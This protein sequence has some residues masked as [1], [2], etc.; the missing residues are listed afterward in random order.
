[1]LFSN[2]KSTYTACR[3]EH[4]VKCKKQVNLLMIVECE[5][6]HYATINSIS[7]LLSKLNGKTQ[8]TYLYCMNCLY[9]FRTWSARYK[10]HEYCSS[11][12]HV[13]VNMPTKKEKWLRFHDGQYQFKVPF[14]LYADFERILKPV[15]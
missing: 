4:N 2:K 3:S 15:N 9:G 6:K 10:H 1:M 14:M 8:R 7:R 13:K 5:K 12:G 11:N